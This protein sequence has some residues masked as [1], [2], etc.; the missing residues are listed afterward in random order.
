LYFSSIVSGKIGFGDLFPHGFLC[1][2]II[3]VQVY[4]SSM[5]M[6]IVF[7]GLSFFLKLKGIEDS[8]G[9]AQ[10]EKRKVLYL[11]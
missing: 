9:S 2:L 5:I 10:R 4:Y 8:E 7:R 6:I 3:M 1:K 11:E